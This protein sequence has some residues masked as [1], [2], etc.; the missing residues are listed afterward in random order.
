MLDLKTM[1]HELHIHGRT[2]RIALIF[3][4]ATVLYGCSTYGNPARDTDQYTCHPGE[5]TDPRLQPLRASSPKLIDLHLTNTGELV[6]R[7]QWT[8]A[9]LQLSEKETRDSSSKVVLLHIH[10]WK[11]GPAPDDTE[12]A[13]F[14]EILE[15]IAQG[16]AGKPQP[17]QVI[18]YFVAWP[19]ARYAL[20]VLN[21]FTFLS[22]LAVA[23]RISQSAV[24]AKF[25]GG[26][27]SALARRVA[28][29]KEDVFI[30]MGYSLGGR[31][32]FNATAQVM[33]YQAQLS[34]P[35]NNET[36][37]RRVDG[38]GDLIILLNPA[39]S[40]SNYTALD[41]I[42]RA[43]EKFPPDQPPVLLTI[44]SDNDLVVRYAYSMGQ[45]LDFN[46]NY[47]QRTAIGEYPQFA[48]HRLS[49]HDQPLVKE[50]GSA[51]FDNFCVEKICL[52]RRAATDLTT[53]VSPF[54]RSADSRPRQ[55]SNPF[56][57]AKATP[58]IVNGHGGAW[59]SK[60]FT[61]WLS[62]FVQTILSK[63]KANNTD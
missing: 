15:G 56:I 11:Q 60:T 47:E 43:D 41:T 39:I 24:V 42:R 57:V 36:H 1:N 16:E 26:I 59:S 46:W 54:A 63:R 2:L 34:R 13:A 32:L 58:D 20:R 37:Y 10:G 61:T 38:P 53:K 21:N 48:T 5:P 27:E 29:G 55:P 52:E 14:K 62:G 12:R 3:L 6:D 35:H 33:L 28:A 7:C 17:K 4:I 22:R 18:G 50:P 25:I 51:W 9:M 23:D 45:W 40:A 19:G 44:S 30:L 31:V 49:I 8:A